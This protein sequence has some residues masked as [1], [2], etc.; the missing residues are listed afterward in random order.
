MESLEWALPWLIVLAVGLAPMLVY[1]LAG[2]IAR[3]LRGRGRRRCATE[4]GA[5]GVGARAPWP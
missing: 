4:K 1:F 5:G 2:V 3:A